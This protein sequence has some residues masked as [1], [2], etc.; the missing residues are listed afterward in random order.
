MNS[1]ATGARPACAGAL[2]LFKFLTEARASASDPDWR[3]PPGN[4]AH[5]A[6][7]H[8]ARARGRRDRPARFI[9]ALG[10]GQS[11]VEVADAF[12]DGALGNG[13]YD[14]IALTGSLP[15]Y[16]PRF[17][18]R[19][20]PG[21]RLF[22]VVGEFPVMEARLVR[23]IGESEWLTETLFETQLPPL[24]GAPRRELFEF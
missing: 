2:F 13:S 17:E 3:P 24:H 4:R 18:R 12:A 1:G 10:L 15:L 16:D 14:V 11:Q 21:G 7:A 23:R 22:V 19:L 20:A 5:G 8:L 9:A 6:R